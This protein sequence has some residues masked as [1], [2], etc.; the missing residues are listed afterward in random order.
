MKPDMVRC[1]AQNCTTK[2]DRNSNKTGMCTFHREQ[3]QKAFRAD[4]K[5]AIPDCVERTVNKGGKCR[6]HS[7]NPRVHL[8]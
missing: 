1:K 2:I 7:H 3:L 4:Y 8:K 5:C 6:K